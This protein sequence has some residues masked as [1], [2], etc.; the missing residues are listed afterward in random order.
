MMRTAAAAAAAATTAD[1]SALVA[2][3]DRW[4]E[5]GR[6]ATLWWRDDDASAPSPQLTRLLRIADGIPLA[7]AVIPALA[8]PEL[9]GAL[10]LVED[11]HIAV[12]QHGW[13]HVDRSSRGKKKSEY[14][15]GRPTTLVAAEIGAGRA[16]LG[17]LFGRRA[18]PL[19]VP[20]W[21]RIAGQF[22]PLLAELGFVGLS[23]MASGRSMAIPAA[24]P[25][26]LA[27]ID[28][29]LDLVAWRGDRGFIGED[30]ALSGLIGCLQAGR[31]NTAAAAATAERPIGILTHHRVMDRATAAFLERLV[32]LTGDHC[33]VRWA[34]AADLI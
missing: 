20:P 19:F 10:A 13:R 14:P 34:A 11:W 31:S 25:A 3:L 5:A 30:L 15:E 8:R 33:A 26:D 17:A 28:V 6:V 16:Y 2:E 21:N 1:W 23:A 12:L 32:G 4:G 9:A 24:I 7:L 22:L 27:R 29:H 18:L